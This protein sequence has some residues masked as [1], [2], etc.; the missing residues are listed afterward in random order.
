ML[1]HDN[2]TWTSRAI[3]SFVESPPAQ[4]QIL[5]FL[6]LGHI[7]AQLFEVYLPITV[8]GTVYFPK[9]DILSVCP[10]SVRGFVAHIFMQKHLV[11]TLQTIRPTVF[12]AVPAIWEK[13]Q[14]HVNE[15]YLQKS[16]GKEK[17]IAS[18]V[19]PL[20]VVMSS[21][22]HIQARKRG[23]LG[24]IKQ[25][26]GESVDFKFK[27]A[28]KMVFSKIKAGLGLDRCRV[29]L[30]GAS[31]FP[32]NLFEFF[33]SVNIPIYD[34]YGPPLHFSLLF[35]RAHLFCRSGRVVWP[36]RCLGAWNPPRW[37]VRQD[38]SRYTDSSHHGKQRD[39]SLRPKHLHGL[40]ERL[41]FH[42]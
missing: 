40:F 7:A 24:S 36:A 11:E 12:F 22:L 32:R 30:N 39:Y 33:L 13:L 27:M 29:C 5:S 16:N 38:L 17:S 26:R 31:S 35:M 2:I 23:M 21:S 34:F 42:C 3:A 25:Q 8:A 9:Q 19:L 15:A 41:R 4:E 6:P 20:A 18:W 37:L 14:H 28:N 10:L 1:S